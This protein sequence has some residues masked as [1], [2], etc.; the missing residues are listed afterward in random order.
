VYGRPQVRDLVLRYYRNQDP[1][2]VRQQLTDEKIWE[3]QVYRQP[4]ERAKPIVVKRKQVE[5]KPPIQ[6]V[7]PVQPISQYGESATSDT[8]SGQTNVD[9]SSQPSPNTV[10]DDP[11]TAS[12]LPT[13]EKSTS[14]PPQTPVCRK[15][16]YPAIESLIHANEGASAQSESDLLWLKQVESQTKVALQQFQL[17]SKLISS[18]LTP[19]SALLKFAGSADLTV[20]QVMK[21][22]SEFLTTHGLNIISVR[23]EAGVVSI[24]VERPKRQIVKLQDLWRHWHPDSEHGNQELLIAVREDDGNLLFLSPDKDHAPHTLIAGSTGS[25][26][27]VLMQNIILVVHHDDRDG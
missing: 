8:E 19:N 18:V 13:S 11:S 14:Q 4:V 7:A 26:K 3:S 6:T 27:S 25:G 23:P 5:P 15:W 12:S 16:S 20:E 1:M 21:R 10:T 2:P 22:R 9:S 24:A 17:R